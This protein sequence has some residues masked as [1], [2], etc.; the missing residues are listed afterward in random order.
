MEPVENLN[1]AMT[2]ALR[3]EAIKLTLN[4]FTVKCSIQ[5]GK[6]LEALIIH[7]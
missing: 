5:K 2:P 1:T 4:S 3:N 6:G 7:R